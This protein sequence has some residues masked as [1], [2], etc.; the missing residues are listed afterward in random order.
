[1]GLAAAES[2]L[3]LNNRFTTLAV[4]AQGHLDEQQAHSFSDEGA[5]K[6]GRNVLILLRSFAG[7]DR[8]D[9]RGKFR[10]QERAFQ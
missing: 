2:C 5:L 7:I 10:L 6:E 1:M 8:R 9:I 3:E 4:Q